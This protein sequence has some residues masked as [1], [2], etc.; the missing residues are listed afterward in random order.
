MEKK[1]KHI[2]NWN[3]IVPSKD[4]LND[5]YQDEIIVTPS[6][7][8]AKCQHNGENVFDKFCDKCEFLKTCFPA[9]VYGDKR[10]FWKP[11]LR[12]DSCIVCEYLGEKIHGSSKYFMCKQTK[13]KGTLKRASSCLHFK[14]NFNL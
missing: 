2:G 13:R 5:T 6:Y 3:F 1:Y 10:D 8:G 7:K 11:K 4:E 9:A 12:D 14:S